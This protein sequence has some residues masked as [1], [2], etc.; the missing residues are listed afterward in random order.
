MNANLGR[1]YRTIGTAPAN[2]L[3]HDDCKRFLKLSGEIYSRESLK[4]FEKR[5]EEVKSMAREI[6]RPL[7]RS[8]LSGEGNSTNYLVC[9]RVEE[10]DY[11][12]NET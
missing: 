2:Y 9:T 11:P 10:R 6:V 8:S 1:V 4:K 12:W 7:M 5:L 3:N